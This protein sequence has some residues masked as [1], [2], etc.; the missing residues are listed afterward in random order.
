MRELSLLQRNTAAGAFTARHHPVAEVV[1]RH[2][3]GMSEDG[4]EAAGTPAPGAGRNDAAGSAA[5]SSRQ[6][7]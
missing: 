5:V 1:V 6:Q 4:A 3:P 2:L 7:S